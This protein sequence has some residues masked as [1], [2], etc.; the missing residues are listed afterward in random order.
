MAVLF[1]DACLDSKSELV[2]KCG[3]Y[4]GACRVFVVKKC[5]GCIERNV[6]KKNRCSYSSCVTDKGLSFCGQC[7]EFPCLEHYGSRPVF[8][9]QK[10][11]NWVKARQEKSS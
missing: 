4:C 9:R 7:E 1:R 2:G 6:V 11:L 10:F 5:N 3:I 8:A